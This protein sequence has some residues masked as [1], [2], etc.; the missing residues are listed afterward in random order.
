MRQLIW[1]LS[2]AAVVVAGGA[3]ATAST[4]T[5]DP[6]AFASASGDFSHTEAGFVVEWIGSGNGADWGYIL[7][8]LQCFPTCA[9]NGTYYALMLPTW[10]GANWA[11]TLR[12]TAADNSA[13][14]FDGF[15]GAE[16][17]FSNN[18]QGMWAS[19]V[20][21]TGIRADAST[22]SEDFFFDLVNDG[23]G[24]QADFQ[25]LVPSFFDVFVE[26]QITGL[27]DPLTGGRDFSID[28]INV[29][30]VPEPGTWM[31]LGTGAVAL[32]VRRRWTRA[33]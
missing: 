26:L 19:G 31:L 1:S 2:V 15:D 28:N 22:W 25:T 3:H 8:G 7:D 27:A 11:P 12:I 5:F 24:G 18:A 20:T 23:L 16:N 21:V 13:F 30:E 6:Q 33:A 14:V 10:E 4:V 9:Q 29:T 17:P 32:L